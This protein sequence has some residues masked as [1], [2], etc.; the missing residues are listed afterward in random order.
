[1]ASELLDLCRKF[2]NENKISC[3]ESI[4]QSDSVIENAYTF[5]EEICN[6]VGYFEYEDE[7]NE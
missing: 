5:I 3:P 6:L 4:Y 2:I 1:M 7:F